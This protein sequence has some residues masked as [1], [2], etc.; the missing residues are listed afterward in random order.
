MGYLF[1]SLAFWSFG[2]ASDFEFRIS[3]FSLPSAFGGYFNQ[4]KANDYAKRTQFP[5]R[6]K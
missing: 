1:W 5:Q 3:D 2:F 4:S 6:Q